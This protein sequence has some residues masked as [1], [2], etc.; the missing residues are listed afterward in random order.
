MFNEIGGP[1]FADLR[2]DP[3]T[4]KSS[5]LST[6]TSKS[7]G[8]LLLRQV[9]PCQAQGHREKPQTLHPAPAWQD[10]AHRTS[11]ATGVKGDVPVVTEQD[12]HVGSLW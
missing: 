2:A 8:T 4:L 3:G 5:F 7:T 12:T 9:G 1:L 11:A 6:V 10:A